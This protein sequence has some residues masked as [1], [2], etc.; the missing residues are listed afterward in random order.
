[1]FIWWIVCV[2][3]LEAY[4]Y[5]IYIPS[6]PLTHSITHTRAYTHTHMRAHTHSHTPTRACTHTHTH[7]HSLTHST[8]TLQLSTLSPPL[9][10]HAPVTHPPHLHEI[11]FVVVL[12]KDVN[13]NG[14]LPPSL[15]H[16]QVARGDGE[17]CGR[18]E[19]ERERERHTH[20][21]A[22]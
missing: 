9:T 20:A 11:D 7:T 14:V 5:H 12:V 1:M 18:E 13:R 17:P 19:T 8:H 22:K 4:S 10:A 2:Y 16:P 3:Q 15:Q 6:P 21:P